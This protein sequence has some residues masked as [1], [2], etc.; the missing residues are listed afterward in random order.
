[1]SKTS[2]YTLTTAYSEL[3][4]QLEDSLIVENIE[5]ITDTLEGIDGS[6]QKKCENIVYVMKNIE[7]PIVAIDAEIERLKKKKESIKNN[8]QR[9]KDYIKQ[10][11]EISGIDEIKTDL[12]TIRLQNSTA[13]IDCGAD[14]LSNVPEEYFTTEIIR[15]FNNKKAVDDLKAGK[16]IVHL[17]LIKGKHIRIY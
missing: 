6:I 7:V 9:L 3:Q 14:M 16:E 2:L 4:Q 15:K 5:Y 11:M 13:K 12:I 1:M 17:K 8:M 10:G